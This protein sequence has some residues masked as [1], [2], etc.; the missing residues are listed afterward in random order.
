V[1]V[2]LLSKPDFTLGIVPLIIKQATI[3][4]L[5]SGS[6]EAFEKM[7]RA[8]EVNKIRPVIDSTYAFADVPKAFDRLAQGAFGKVV[9][10]VDS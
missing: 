5:T 6:R 10:R 7:N 2:G 8:L 3:H 4:T 1:I 9:I